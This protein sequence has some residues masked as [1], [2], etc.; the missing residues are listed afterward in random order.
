[1]AVAVEAGLAQVITV[2]FSSPCASRVTSIGVSLSFKEEL[3]LLVGVEAKIE[4]KEDA[5]TKVCKSRP[6]PFTLREKVEEAIRQQVA[7]GKL[8]AVDQVF[9]QSPMWW[10]SLRRMEI[11]V[12]VQISR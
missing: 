5:K 1:M 2:S 3:G 9:G 11:F 8:E 10:W 12:L 4:L 6:M 7:D